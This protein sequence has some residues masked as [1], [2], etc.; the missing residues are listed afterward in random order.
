MFVA[1][2]FAVAAAAPPPHGVPAGGPARPEDAAESVSALLLDVADALRQ[3]DAPRVAARLD[4][5]ASFPDPRARAGPDEPAGPWWVAHDWSA[6][7]GP[8]LG[9]A[10]FAAALVDRLAHFTALDD[11]ALPVAAARGAGDEVHADVLVSV[12]G[13]D[14]AGRREWKRGPAR[15]RARRASGAWRVTAF[16]LGAMR[17]LAATREA[18]DEVSL[19]AGLAPPPP[20]DDTVGLW[21]AWPGAAA[22][23]FDGDGRIDLFVTGP[24][25]NRLYLNRGGR[26]E[27]SPDPMLRDAGGP[28]TAATGPA[29]P[30]ALDFDNDGDAD[31]FV[32][33]IGRQALLEN[34]RVPDGALVFRDISLEAG[35][36]R[37]AVGIGATAA[38]VNGD[39]R[40]DVYVACYNA[41]GRLAPDSWLEAENGTPNLLFVSQPDGSYREE[42][43]RWGVADRRWSL[44]A[45]FAD[46]DGDGA[47]DLY[48]A[49]DFGVKGL[50][51]RRGG[52]F[53]DEAAAR[54]ARD[55]GYGMGV[56]VGDYDGDGV[57][58]LHAT[59]MSGVAASR[60]IA[61]A[62]PPPPLREALDRRTAGN[63][64]L[65][66]LGGGRFEDVTASAG[67]L[68]AGWAWGGGLVDLDNDGRADLFTP[69]GFVSGPSRR[70]TQALF[71]REVVGRESRPGTP[72]G[73]P[74]EQP[75]L[76]F[77]EGWSF[78]GH[79]R[80]ALFAG[81]DGRRFEDVSGISGLDSPTDGRAAVF[82]D[83][84]DDGDAD[85]FLTT[86]GGPQHLLFRNRLGADAGWLRVIVEGRASGRDAF[87]TVVRARAGARVFVR[88]KTGG[89]GFLSQHDPRLLFGLGTATQAD[90]LEVVWPGGRTERFAGP[91]PARST[92]RI[93]EG[94][95]RAEAVEVRRGSLPDP[96]TP[97]D[98]AR[99]RLRLREGGALPP[100][101]VTP[102]AGGAGAAPARPA[103]LDTLRPANGRSVFAFVTATCAACPAVLAALERERRR[104]EASGARVAAVLLDTPAEAD[105]RRLLAAAGM[106]G[107]DLMAGGPPAARVLFVGG[108]PEPPLL[109]VL[110]PGGRVERVVP[111]AGDAV[112]AVEALG[113]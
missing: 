45:T 103:R 23:D 57:L 78:N 74:A 21:A 59:N 38:D 29:A 32:A 50:F 113:R 69:N 104:L 37:E 58:D 33:A 73:F 82:A 112:A 41:L 85:V 100:L 110:D 93:V 92:I 75:R 5:A 65:R 64:L 34:R 46:L 20:P 26:F 71:W 102:R 14:P 79:E 70:D 94:T 96:A 111:A 4:P 11:I 55:P 16:E 47:L 90:V 39:G 42:A 51:M 18:F 49:N 13:R 53:V 76:M 28:S 61:R 54:G 31:V 84:D 89:E 83:L 24:V 68:P 66:G 86:R 106:P 81:V 30:L 60:V 22:A 15:V 17:S 95:G 40:P 107:L 72:A 56:S 91:F 35:V 27:E 99:H 48:V 43:E 3:R 63:T 87:G 9:A 8:P 7:D 88:V 52:R 1:L 2:A 101:V 67:P 44:A 77:T 105:L 12:V 108:V 19:P 97:A 25:Q 80:D 98:R 109:V 36:A 62:A 10:R 6:V